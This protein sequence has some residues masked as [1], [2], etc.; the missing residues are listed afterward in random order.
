LPLVPD[1]VEDLKE[2]HPQRARGGILRNRLMPF[3]ALGDKTRLHLPLSGLMTLV[4]I[5]SGER[6]ASVWRR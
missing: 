3:P 6:H 2:E 4:T 1:G 5:Q